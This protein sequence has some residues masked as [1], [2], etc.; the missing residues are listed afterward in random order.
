GRAMIEAEQVEALLLEA[1]GNLN[2]E[3]GQDRKIDVRRDTILFGREAELHSLTLVSFVVAVEAMLQERL[4]VPISLIDERPMRR[5]V[6][7]FRNVQTLKD[8][9]LSIASQ[10]TDQAG[11]G[12]CSISTTPSMGCTFRP[13]IGGFWRTSPPARSAW[14]WP[15]ISIRR[16]TTSASTTTSLAC[17]RR[18]RPGLPRKHESNPDFRDSGCSRR[19]R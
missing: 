7:P 3:L 10:T 5:A 19:P 11:L 15:P 1:L 4:G 17:C 12:R 14:R 13:C 8:Y 9:I 16:P 18:K 6:S 2:R